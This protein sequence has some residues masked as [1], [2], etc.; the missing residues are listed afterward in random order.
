MVICLHDYLGHG[1]SGENQVSKLSSQKVGP[2]NK[3]QARSCVRERALF[4]SPEYAV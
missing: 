3:R 4:A 2:A 1:G